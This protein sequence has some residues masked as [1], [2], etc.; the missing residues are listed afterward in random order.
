MSTHQSP[1]VSYTS[2]KK[3]HHTTSGIIN[4]ND[5]KISREESKKLLSKYNVKLP[6]SHQLEIV[7][8]V[9]EKELYKI[10]KIRGI[11]GRSAPKHIILDMLVS[12]ILSHQSK[13]KTEIEFYCRLRN[14]SLGQLK[15]I[16]NN[17]NIKVKGKK[18]SYIVSI[19]NVWSENQEQEEEEEEEGAEE[20][21]QEYEEPLFIKPLVDDILSDI[22]NN[23][24]EKK[25]E[26][27][28]KKYECECGSVVLLKSRNR[29]MKSKKHIRY[30]QQ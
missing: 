25:V 18:S 26:Y 6:I 8:L 29:H 11:Q 1:K 27:K 4:T 3:V 21:K 22:I 2:S 12:D 13:N 19:Y 7:N 16:S 9:L 20:T 15:E 24:Q 23:I 17:M 10:A 28:H 30:T 14:M 5:K